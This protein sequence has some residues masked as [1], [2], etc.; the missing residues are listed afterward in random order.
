MMGKTEVLAPAGNFAMVEAG[1][2]GGADS[3]YL[4][5][6]DFGA[7][8]YAENF[9]IENIKETI[10][11]IHLFGKRIFVTMNTLIK[12]E[13]MAKA[14]S[15]VEKLYEFGC[16]GL[17]IQDLGFFSIIRDQVPG[18]ELHASTQMAVREYYGAKYLAKLGFD[19]IVIARETPVAEIRKIASLD[20]E[21]EVFV[22]GSLCV[23]FSGEC[24]MSSY[25]GGRS[26]NRGRC[27]GPCRQK[28]DLISDGRVLANDYF[29]NM[30]DLNV[31]DKMD[32][33]LDIGVDCIKIEGR[34][35][36]AEYVYTAVS[37]YRT[38]IDNKFYHPEEIADSTNRGFTQGY[39]FD[40]TRDNV[41]LS[42]DNKHRSVGKV[43]TL[44]NQ[45]YFIT[46]TDLVLGD[47]LE[48]TTDREK[49][50]PFT[51]TRAY[52]KGEKILLEKYRD[53]KTDSDVLLVNSNKLTM[54]LKE[55][56]ASYRNLPVKIKFEARLGDFPKITIAS[57]DKEA[58]YIHK[59][60]AEEAKKISLSAD[61]I[62]ENLAKFNDEIFTPTE[63]KI[64]IDEGIFLRKKDINECRRMAINLLEKEITGDFHRNPLKIAYS[65]SKKSSA[66]PRE[67][68]IEVL[69]SHVSP[70]LLE[71]F[72]NIYI[73]SFDEK[74]RG[75]N[76]Y[77]NL[78]SHDEYDI[79]DLLAYLKKNEIQGVILNNYR[80]LDFID[81]FKAN[82]IKIRI[83]RYLNVLNSYTFDF[84]SNFAE[85]ISSSVENNFDNINKN[86]KNLPVEALAFGRI[87]LMNMRHCPFSPIKKCGLVGCPTCKFNDGELRSHDGQ[88]MRVIRYGSYSK[89][90]PKDPSLVQIDNFDTNVSV[91]YQVLSD[92]DIVNI[93]KA[94]IRNTYQKG[95]I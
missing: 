86:A 23:S 92:D 77:L 47:N 21:T 87:E 12:D 45:K 57:T 3:F 52:K 59:V 61:D 72:D 55:G 66:K 80:D 53:A 79:S 78:D 71:D 58:R 39:I 14:I 24:L 91:L 1:L 76:L 37:N 25:F 5:L 85:M 93:N 51:T 83:G 70:E 33:L 63:I 95:V 75:L 38:R 81:D 6:D 41:T 56:L 40:Q 10:D 36:T 20:V 54:N 34:M 50:L 42:N 35:K 2:A 64:D 94:K 15:Y 4:A 90:Y 65:L 62:R 27:A 18:M 22:H 9:T 44:K 16:D 32:E 31:I 30:K 46:E 69:T 13:E 84:Y 11:Y 73:R 19:R 43:K 7:R 8:A 29:L 67:R 88:M 82:N 68:N 89:I 74:Y 60:R 26:A 48:I 28:Y 49:K 17:I